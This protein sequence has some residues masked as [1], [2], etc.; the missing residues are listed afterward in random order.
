MVE[1][2]RP[3]VADNYWPN[4]FGPTGGESLRS[5]NIS[6]NSAGSLVKVS[7]PVSGNFKSCK[8]DNQNRKAPTRNINGRASCSLLSS[9]RTW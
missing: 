1:F 7:S 5:T 3:I 6:R 8:R 2:I 9:G 4:E